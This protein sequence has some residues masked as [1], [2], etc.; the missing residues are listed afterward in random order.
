MCC[1]RY[2]V[3]ASTDTACGVEYAGQSPFITKSIWKPYQRVLYIPCQCC[4]IRGPDFRAPAPIRP[5]WCDGR[6]HIS[7]LNFVGCVVSGGEVAGARVQFYVVRTQRRWRIASKYAAESGA[8]DSRRRRRCPRVQNEKFIRTPNRL[9]S[10]S[11]CRLA[12]PTD[13]TH[14]L[15]DRDPPLDT[16]H[17]A[18]ALPHHRR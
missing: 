4:A 14:A 13:R 2:C 11:H 17:P 18:F 12:R 15:V 8:L 1:Q 5:V 10:P 6:I 9:P 3:S 7:T 16:S